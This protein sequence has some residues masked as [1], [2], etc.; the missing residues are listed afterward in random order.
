MPEQAT[1]IWVS[2]K[3]LLYAVFIIA[4]VVSPIAL[5]TEYYL[6]PFA[7]IIALVVGILIIT[8][9]F[10]GLIIY[11]VFL[12]IRPQE[13]VSALENSPVP[14][15]RLIALLL[16][17]SVILKIITKG[18][19]YKFSRVDYAIFAF[20]AVCFLS[21]VG[22]VYISHSIDVSM[23][24]VRLLIIYLLVILIVDSKRQ[25]KLFIL[26]ILFSSAFHAFAS[27]INYFQGN[28]VSNVA[29]GIDRAVGIDKSF[30]GPNSLAATLVYT[31]PMM[32]FYYLAE[33]SHAIKAVI[34]GVTPVIVL[35]IILTGS[36]SGMVG[37]LFFAL[38]VIWNSRNR[39]RN[40]VIVAIL[41]MLSWGAMPDQYRN[42]FASVT[43]LSSETSSAKSANARVE[44]LVKGL[45]MLADRPLTGCGIGNYSVASGTIYS[46][47]DW[48][49]SHSLPGQI[50][51]EIGILGTLA[52]CI[53]IYSLLKTL[54]S[55]Q[56][57]CRNSDD[58][59]LYLTLIGLRMQLF[60]LLLLGL[61]GHNL[62]RYNWFIV[63]ALIVVSLRLYNK[64]LDFN[65]S[66]RLDAP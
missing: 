63:S 20:V 7:L 9:P 32:Y 57:K 10:V 46:V 49:N 31:L 37:L 39:L 16:I 3:H 2:Q 59:F 15:E 43:D 21:I 17:I 29:M 5:T 28:Y 14:L 58:N 26:F 61:S 6:L 50:F 33:R 41:I 24:L 44:G 35:C 19:R 48:H 25:M 36:R 38:M 60:C 66:A 30:S 42:R 56:L 11:S 22:S 55:L 1:R 65:S 23:D 12:F 53:W 18:L 8:R 4:C 54:K 13:F 62:Y 34:I 40:F 47:G 51:G 45:R 64:E 52:F 27:V